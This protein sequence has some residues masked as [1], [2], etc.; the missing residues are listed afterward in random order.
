MHEVDFELKSINLMDTQEVPSGFKDLVSG[1]SGTGDDT[2]TGTGSETGTGDETNDDAGDD[3]D[4]SEGG[5]PEYPV[6]SL[7][8]G[9]VLLVLL[10][11]RKIPLNPI[12][13]VFFY[14][15]S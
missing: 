1:E 13:Q 7:M 10:Y 8:L 9:V 14:S 4:T 2:D 11:T 5:I 15:F 12:E 3:S 6:S